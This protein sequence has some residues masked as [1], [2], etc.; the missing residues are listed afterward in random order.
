MRK[1]IAVLYPAFNGGGAQSVCLWILETLKAD[2][3]LTLFTLTPDDFKAAD[4]TYGTQLAGSGIKVS[5]PIADV[6]VPFFRTL[7]FRFRGLRPY[8]QHLLMRHFKKTKRTFD[9]VIS[10]YNEVDIGQPAIQY[11]H[12][13]PRFATGGGLLQTLSDYSEARTKENIMLAPS[14]W[15]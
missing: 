4:R 9:L 10:G 15:M 14:C 8:R 6:W 3:E 11:M 13:V 2:Y 1:S 7:F 12:N 5:S